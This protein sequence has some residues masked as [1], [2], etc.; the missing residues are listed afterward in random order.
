MNLVF[1]G[2]SE[3]AKKSLLALSKTHHNIVTVCSLPGVTAISCLANELKMPLSQPQDI[4]NIET[5][6]YLK[7]LAPDIFVVV[8]Y[9]R[10]L[11][12]QIL[13]VPRLY[14]INLHGS[15]LPKYR[16]AAPVHW[17][18]MNG[19]ANTGV[20]IFRINERLDSGDIILQKD[21]PISYS[22]TS[23]TLSGQL[24]DVGAKAVVEALSL[25]EEGKVTFTPQDD[26]E[27]SYAPKL[28]KADGLINWSNPASH[29]Y[30]QVRGVQ[31]WPGAFTFWEGKRLKII[32]AVCKAQGASKNLSPF[33]FH[34][35]P[36]HGEIIAIDR[37]GIVVNTGEGELVIKELQMEGAKP[38]GS[39][40]FSLGHRIKVGD[41][42]CRN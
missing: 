42:L 40:E 5:K 7:G 4:N 12:S 6:A 2:S 22:D 24:S 25:I 30:N 9:G 15:L 3:F 13:R 21:I 17:A 37:D 11:S 14:A 41:V 26:T 8:S 28:N 27:A 39:F 16:G 29:I 38:M 31:P 36:K 32:G 19:E 34:L 33:T 23:I 20:T 1:F 10:I 35:S 18:I